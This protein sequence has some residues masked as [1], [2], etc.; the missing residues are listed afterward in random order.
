VFF[1]NAKALITRRIKT[2]TAADDGEPHAAY[3]TVQSHRADKLVKQ[4]TILNPSWD[5]TIQPTN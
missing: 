2:K 1:A 3:R 5:I 4:C